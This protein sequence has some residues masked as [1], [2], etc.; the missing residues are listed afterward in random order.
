MRFCS[1]DARGAQAVSQNG[2]WHSERLAEMRLVAPLL[3]TLCLCFMSQAR[4]EP[5]DLK[6][7]TEAYAQTTRKIQ[8]LV[9]T[10]PWA[11]WGES[12]RIVVDESQAAHAEEVQSFRRDFLAIGRTRMAILIKAVE[13]KQIGLHL[14]LS[15]IEQATGFA[16][17][18]Q[19]DSDSFIGNLW[20]LNMLPPVE[21]SPNLYGGRVGSPDY[22]G[23]SLKISFDAKGI[24]TALEFYLP[25]NQ[26]KPGRQ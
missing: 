16:D 8:E 18:S 20:V 7:A 17:E 14:P 24:V 21:P 15:R 26:M 13:E 1:R 2:R 9:A 22:E 23:W 19:R 5:A 6:E 4:G 25:G 12:G 11:R 3:F 10:N